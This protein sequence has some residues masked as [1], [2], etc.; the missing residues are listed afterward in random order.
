MSTRWYFGDHVNGWR[1]WGVWICQR[2]FVGVC[3][4]EPQA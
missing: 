4:K 2:W 3:V 1:I